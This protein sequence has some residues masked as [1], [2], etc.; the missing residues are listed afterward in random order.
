MFFSTYTSESLRFVIS[1]GV[2]ELE[3]GEI[4]EEVCLERNLT[5]SANYT[6]YLT[7]SFMPV[8]PFQIF[9]VNTTSEVNC[10][11]MQDMGEQ[12]LCLCLAQGEFSEK[13]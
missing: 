3:P 2:F 6:D 12:K 7:D 4:C 13:K 5:C 1:P 8:L 11:E 10:T 9:T